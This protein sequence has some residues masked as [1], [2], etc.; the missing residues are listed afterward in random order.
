MACIDAGN[1]ETVGLIV[2]HRWNLDCVYCFISEKQSRD[3]PIETAVSIL[4]P[5]LSKE[6]A[7]P[8]QI[9]LMGGEPL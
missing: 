7:P 8:L 6:N 4:R 1:L 9:M 3:M 5:L 2:T